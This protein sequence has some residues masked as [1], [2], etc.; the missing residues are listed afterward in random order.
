MSDRFANALVTTVGVVPAVVLP[1]AVAYLLPAAD[2]WMSRRNAG[3][4]PEIITVTAMMTAALAVSVGTCWYFLGGA[5]WGKVL[6]FV[7]AA[8]GVGFILLIAWNSC[9]MPNEYCSA[10]P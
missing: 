6:V 3:H 1:I 7:L 5:P 10:I 8:A 9:L 2:S 4:E